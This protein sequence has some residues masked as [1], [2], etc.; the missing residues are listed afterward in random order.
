[1]TYR[2]VLHKIGQVEPQLVVYLT[3]SIVEA[4]RVMRLFAAGKGWTLERRPDV[5]TFGELAIRIERSK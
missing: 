3:E 5:H 4:R 2:V 1:M